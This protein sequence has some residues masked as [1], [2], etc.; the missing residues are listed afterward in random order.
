MKTLHLPFIYLF[1][2]G[3]CWCTASL[4]QTSN[5][6]G[7]EISLVYRSSL[8]GVG[9]FSARD[10]Y[11]SPLEYTGYSLYAQSERMSMIRRFDNKVSQQHLLNILFSS[12]KNVT[13]TATDYTAMV[14]Y[15]YAQHYHFR[16]STAWHLLAGAQLFVYGGAVYNTRNGNNPVAAKAGASLNLS[17]IANYNFKLKRL[18]VSLKYQG[19]VSTLGASFSPHYGQSYYEISLGNHEGLLHFTRWGNFLYARNLFTVELPV[20]SLTLRL[21]YQHYL[22]NTHLSKLK[23]QLSSHAFMLGF[24]KEIFSLSA[25]QRNKNWLNSNKLKR[26]YE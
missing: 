19:V 6:N 26:V 15:G 17:G 21:G 3:L 9:S 5:A 8:L 23:T 11:L 22:Y 13:E 1:F 14:D 25:N 4:A 18:P 16:P 24:V 12:T 10:S 7:Q 2:C 20:S